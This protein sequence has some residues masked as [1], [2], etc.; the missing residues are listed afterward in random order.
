MSSLF[1]VPTVSSDIPASCSASAHLSSPERRLFRVPQRAGT[2][3]WQTV[4]ATP[5]ASVSDRP[6]H[7]EA[8]LVRKHDEPGPVARVELHHRPADVGLGRG[9]AHDEALGNLV[10]P[11][12]EPHE[13]DY[14]A[15]SWG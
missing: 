11:E 10:V 2:A 8:Q 9:R 15:L 1:S 5:C 4:P 12:S 13:P 14:L 6:G 7:R 3:A